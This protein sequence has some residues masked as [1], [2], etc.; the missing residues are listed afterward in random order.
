V[1][2]C[3]TLVPVHVSLEKKRDVTARGRGSYFD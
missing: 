1:T 2:G 3:P